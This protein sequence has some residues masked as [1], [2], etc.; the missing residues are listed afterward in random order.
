MR[1]F[2]I[3]LKVSNVAFLKEK[4]RKEPVLCVATGMSGKQCHSSCSKIR[5]SSLFLQLTNCIVRHALLKISQCR[6]KTLSQLLCT[7]DWYSI[8]ALLQYAPH[9]VIY[10]VE[11]RTVGWPHVRTDELGCL[12]AQKLDCV[13]STMCWR[14]VLL[15]G[16]HI[17]NSMLR[18]LIA[19]SASATRLGYTAR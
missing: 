5:A 11:V 15:Q 16:K 12:M 19:A 8:H 7:A 10:L 4:K 6:N 9:M 2:F 14:I 3:R 13:T 1:N 18:S 17:S